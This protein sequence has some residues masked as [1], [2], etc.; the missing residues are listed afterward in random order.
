[1]NKNK[2][3]SITTM[4]LVNSGAFDREIF[5]VTRCFYAFIQLFINDSYRVEYRIFV[6]VTYDNW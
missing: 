1:M 4:C 6:V 3:N 5:L 2:M